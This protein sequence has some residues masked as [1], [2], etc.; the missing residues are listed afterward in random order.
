L[1]LRI[2]AQDQGAWRRLVRLYAPLVYRWCRASGLPP[3]AAADVG[4]EIFRAVARKIDTF[5]RDQSGGSFLRWLRALARHQIADHHSRMLVDASVDSCAQ[6]LVQQLPE[7]VPNAAVE[8]EE[9]RALL[10][11]ALELLRMELEERTWRAVWQTA[12]DGLSA[13]A[14]AA[15]LGMTAEAVYLA[16][17]R[18]RRRLREELEDLEAI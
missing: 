6:T 15:E 14:V 7:E 3:V 11:R 16:T 1:L 5:H 18:M 12:V 17:A 4:E 8:T 10:S 2:R 9:A 13:V